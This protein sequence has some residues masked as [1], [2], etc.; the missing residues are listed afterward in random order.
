MQRITITQFTYQPAVQDF[1]GTVTGVLEVD[2]NGVRLRH[3]GEGWLQLRVPD[4]QSGGSLGAEEDPLRWAELLP[5]TVRGGDTDVTVE[6][7]ADDDESSLP[8]VA[9]PAIAALAAAVQPG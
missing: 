3:G 4:P 9:T 8:D 6:E 1:A 2:E 5:A 7:V